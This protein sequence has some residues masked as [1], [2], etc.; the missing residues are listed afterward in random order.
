MD[1][2]E[3]ENIIHAS[4]IWPEPGSGRHTIIWKQSDYK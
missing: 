3:S 1:K 2:I 4:T